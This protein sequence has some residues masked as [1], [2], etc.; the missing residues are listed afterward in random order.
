MKDSEAWAWATTE[1]WLAKHRV[2]PK[3]SLSE[4]VGGRGWTV[5]GKWGPDLSGNGT[6]S[7]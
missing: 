6:S 4:A 1:S 5:V 3:E 7:M 2:E